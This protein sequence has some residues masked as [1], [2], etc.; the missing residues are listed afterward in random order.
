MLNPEILRIIEDSKDD[1]W[2]VEPSTKRIL[3][4]S[5][6]DVMPFEV[7]FDIDEA[8][9]QAQKL[10]YPLAAKVVSP[11]IMHKSDVGGYPK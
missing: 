5:G 10:G 1:G 2:V 8:R 4:L 3:R 11:N 9:K 7:A 6:I